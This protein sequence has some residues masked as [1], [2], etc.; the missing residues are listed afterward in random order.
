MKP[1]LSFEISVGFGW[2][3]RSKKAFQGEGD[4]DSDSV[5]WPTQSK[6]DAYAGQCLFYAELLPLLYLSIP[7]PPVFMHT[8][9]FPILTAT[10]WHRYLPP[11]SRNKEKS[12]WKLKCVFFQVTQPEVDDREL[13]PKCFWVQTLYFPT[14]QQEK[15]PPSSSPR[16][17]PSSLPLSLFS[18]FT[19]QEQ[20]WLGHRLY[21]T[22]LY[23][24]AS[25]SCLYEDKKVLNPKY[26]YALGERSKV[27]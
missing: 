23:D 1:K 17:S 14:I 11:H 3:E 4:W 15:D 27:S 9:P 24:S 21:K 7:C 13:N 12:L 8:V 16:L 2:M 10:L 25:H 26:L 6:A 5:L 19:E 18:I 22:N 20:H